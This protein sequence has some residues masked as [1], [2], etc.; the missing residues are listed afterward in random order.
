MKK[1]L[2]SLMLCLLMVFAI[3]PLSAVDA[4]A[5]REAWSEAFY[6]FTLGGEYLK[7]EQVYYPLGRD[8]YDVD[9]YYNVRFGL[10]DIDGDGIPELI[11]FN[12]ARD[13]AWIS[14]IYTWW[15][16]KVTY[17]GS[18]EKVKCGEY[19]QKYGTVLCEKDA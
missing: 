12:G 4:Y 18:A 8:P 5:A 3:L 11:A 13:I 6:N 10:H 9:G 17:L 2:L 16:G 15:N 7:C 1:S 19:M 14:Y